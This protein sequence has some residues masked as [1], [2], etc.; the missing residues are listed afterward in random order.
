[1]DIAIYIKGQRLDLFQDESIEMNL[2]AKN[3]SDISKIFAD[4]TQGFTIPASPNNNKIF[5]YWYDATVD[6]TNAN[7]RIDS[8]IEINTLPYK[9]GS[10]Q[11]DGAK[12]KDGLPYSYAITFFGNAVNLSDLFADLEL[13]DLPLSAYDH[14]YNNTIVANAIHKDTIAGGDVYYL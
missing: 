1:M 7:L 13:K 8:L 14:D 10:I 3:I 12:L 9:F 4:F 6:G 5:E 11:L 2:N